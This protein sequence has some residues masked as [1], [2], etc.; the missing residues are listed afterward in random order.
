[1]HEGSKIQSEKEV[2]QGWLTIED[3][4]YLG[5]K[6]SILFS[7]CEA[8]EKIS[9]MYSIPS[10]FKYIKFWHRSVYKPTCIEYTIDANFNAFDVLKFED[11]TSAFSGG[12]MTEMM[13]QHH[14]TFVLAG[15]PYRYFVWMNTSA[16][17]P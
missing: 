12:E 11:L 6:T 17:V 13:H 2:V 8:T 1:M 10:G 14:K 16:P 4:Q 15:I 7:V 9:D 5:L 3:Q